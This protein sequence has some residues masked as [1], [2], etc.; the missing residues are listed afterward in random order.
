L[1]FWIN[2]YILLIK[3]LLFYTWLLNILYFGVHWFLVNGRRLKT[4]YWLCRIWTCALIGRW[5][6]LLHKLIVMLF[7]WTIVS[8]YIFRIRYDVHI[9]LH[10]VLIVHIWLH[11]VLI[12][13]IWLHFVLIVHIWLHLVLIVHIWLHLVLIRSI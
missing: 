2:N 3:V 6:A 8:F 12:V 7:V 10:L 13:H 9:W 4:R 5:L 1:F 11:L